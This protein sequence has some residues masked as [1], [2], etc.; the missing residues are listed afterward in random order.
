VTLEAV[1]RQRNV[2]VVDDRGEVIPRDQ[3]PWPVL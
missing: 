3:V 2:P 1:I